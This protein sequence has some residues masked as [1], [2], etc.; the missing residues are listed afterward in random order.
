MGA[1]QG[2][3]ATPQGVGAPQSMGA[4]QGVGAPQ[5]GGAGP[6]DGAN[7][8]VPPSRELSRSTTPTPEEADPRRR[9]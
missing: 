2:V 5:A 1:P 4:P 8:L 9:R 7:R 6:G 3:G